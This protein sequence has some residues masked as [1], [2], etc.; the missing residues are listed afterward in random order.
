MQTP[1]E[2]N[3]IL[4]QRIATRT[5]RNLSGFLPVF[6]DD[7]DR[8][9]THLVKLL[10]SFLSRSSFMALSWS[11]TALTTLSRLANTDSHED[12]LNVISAR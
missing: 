1:N 4:A 6:L 11:L 9:T 7:I 3:V 12:S 10:P 2:F 5:R 8:K